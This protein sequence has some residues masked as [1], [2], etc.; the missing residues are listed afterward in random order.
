VTLLIVSA[1][2]ALLL[3]D[4][5]IVNVAVPAIAE[6]L[7]ASFAQVQ[8]VIDAYALTLSS[9]LLAI[10]SL[11]DRIG[12]RRVFEGGLLLFTAASAGCALAPS[13]V[14]LDVAR[15]VQGLGAAAIFAPALAL[16]AASYPAGAERARALTIWGLVTGAALAVGPVV[17][18]ALVDG[19][20]WEWA[21]W[22]NLPLGLALIPLAARHVPESRDPA[23]RTPDWPGAALFTGGTFL[24]VLALIQDVEAAYPAAAV[25]LGAFAFVEL[26][27]AAPMI[28]LR[29][30]ARPQFSGTAMVSFTQSFAQYPLF[31]FLAIY[32]QGD[33][34][35]SP[36]EAG[37]R[38][39]PA[40]LVLFLVA[41]LSARMTGRLPL[42]VPLCLGLLLIGTGALLLRRVSPGGEW[43]ELL[44][45][46][47]VGG[48][49][50]GTISP[51]L[52]AAMVAVLP[53][54]QSGLSSGINNTFRQL[55]IAVGIAVLGAIFT[56]GVPGLERVFLTCGLVAVLSAPV[57][58]VLLRGLR[59]A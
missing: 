38:L 13:A 37:I 59:N 26:R 50:I 27:S 9:T 41:P 53:V 34:G 52:A 51:A 22:I 43:T 36:F 44:P 48:M 45:G 32:L 25:L 17:G 42:R 21:F 19:L 54:D 30:F 4:V 15:G 24:L 18:G 12:R 39:L 1:A 49:G 56:A 46:F 33:L 31:L 29:L 11:A 3:L 35:Y 58:W 7:D 8:W 55:G 40:T 10:G 16:L 28:D 2:T 47:V 14:F 57:A 23:A 5:T 6:D 20:A